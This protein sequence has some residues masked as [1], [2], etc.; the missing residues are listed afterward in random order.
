[1]KTKVTIALTSALMLV[2]MSFTIVP[3]ESTAPSCGCEEGVLFDVSELDGGT[4]SSWGTNPCF[5]GLDFRVRNTR[6]NEYAKKYHWEVQ[7]R[8]CYNQKAAF[9]YEIVPYHERS[10]I[11]RSGR[12]TNRVDVAAN[13]TER[14]THWDLVP[15]ANQVFVYVNKMRFGASSWGDYAPC[16]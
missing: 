14:G 7:F 9:N 15:E 12:T 4:W 11:E 13:T 2:L 3:S 5:R 6:Y 8:N 16:D 10:E 1:M